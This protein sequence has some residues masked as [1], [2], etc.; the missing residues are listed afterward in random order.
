ME[1]NLT[2]CL[3]AHGRV[4]CSLCFPNESV[5]FDRS[6]KEGDGWRITA[7]PMA[8]GTVEPEVVVL[9]F[10]KGPTQAGAL[11]TSP[12]DEI[13]YKGSR[14][15]VG[16]ILAHIKLMP[17]GTSEQLE[18]SVDRLIS[19][20]HGRFH[21]SSFIRCTVERFD[22]KKQTWEGSGG[23]ML[24]RFVSTKFGSAVANR[25]ASRFLGKLP[26]TVRLVVMFGLGTKLNY[27]DSAF[28]VFQAVRP[29][30]WAK[31]N[32]VAHTDGHLMVVHVEHFASQGALTP[33]WLGTTAKP[34]ADLGNQAREAVHAVLVSVRVAPHHMLQ[35]AAESRR[36]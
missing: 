30:A 14:K 22:N 34:R 33:D 17:P 26:P 21:F 2:S 24:D 25:C 8:W 35:R 18:R 20:R 4:A 5:E 29:A 16:K 31:F 6:T 1:N 7:N 15:N 9:G 12:H 11:S 27:V 3:P 28:A 23:G 32:D 36:R 13:A 10:S 19:D